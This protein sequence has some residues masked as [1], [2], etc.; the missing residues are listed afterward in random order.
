MLFT[1]SS[2][3]H[4]KAQVTRFKKG[5]KPFLKLINTC[6]LSKG[7]EEDTIVL[8]YLLPTIHFL[9]TSQRDIGREHTVK[10]VR[11]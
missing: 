8:A 2:D 1:F 10:C 3:T 6:T 7:V 4:S 11:I 9:G 5:K